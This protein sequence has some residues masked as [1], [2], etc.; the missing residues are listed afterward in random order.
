M[1]TLYRLWPLLVLLM[2]SSCEKDEPAKTTVQFGSMTLNVTHKVD[3]A[4]LLFDSMMYQ[5]AAGNPFSVS[6][7]YYYISGIR[8][9]NQE[10]LMFTSNAIFYIDATS[11]ENKLLLNYVPTGE[12]TSATLLIGLA[13]DTN[14][15]GTLPDLI[16][17]LN[18]AWP[19]EMGGGYHFMKLE[20]HYRNT[21]N[22]KKGFTVHLG[23]N[24]SLVQHQAIPKN[25][26]VTLGQNT[27]LTLEMNI[28]EWFANPY[29]YNFNTDGNY[30][31]GVA[32]LMQLISNNGK[33]VF[34]LR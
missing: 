26:S 5:N 4:P 25:F 27:P 18:M 9:Y 34:T 6:R 13:A 17:N 21:A 20:G 28:N 22:L 8:L 31:M 33:D 15:T 3:Q 30:T 10:K 11:A 16:E 23:T 24:P 1:K 2:A 7:L 12:Y 32:L 29:A 14:K 19:D